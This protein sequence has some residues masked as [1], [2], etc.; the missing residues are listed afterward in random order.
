MN[1]L[2]L[3]KICEDLELIIKGLTTGKES[4]RE[5][6]TRYSLE[7]ALDY[8]QEYLQGLKNLNN[9]IVKQGNTPELLKK[10][11]TSIPNFGFS[12][13]ISQLIT[14]QV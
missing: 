7:E 11:T 3:N 12:S 1:R 14:F 5:E 13:C 8:L 6:G 9:Q 2:N 10:S 4:Y